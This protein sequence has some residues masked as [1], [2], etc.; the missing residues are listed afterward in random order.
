[1]ANEVTIRISAKSFCAG[2]VA[3]D[4]KVVRAAPIIGYMVG[5]DGG[6]VA[7]YCKKKGWRWVRSTTRETPPPP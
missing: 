2:L 7:A 1:M 4:G 5:W 3:R 6:R